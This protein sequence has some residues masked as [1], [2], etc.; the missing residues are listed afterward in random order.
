MHKDL[1]L[2]G[3]ALHAIATSAT[4]HNTPCR[5]LLAREQA[6]MRS[7]Y[8]ERL[9]ELERERVTAEAD[10]AQARLPPILEPC[11]QHDL[12]P[13][14]HAVLPSGQQQPCKSCWLL[15]KTL[16]SG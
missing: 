11:S 4:V 14:A 1:V 7:E 3:Q 2:Q 12:L 13:D 10:K 9:R 16:H 8:E 5:T 15:L 6:R